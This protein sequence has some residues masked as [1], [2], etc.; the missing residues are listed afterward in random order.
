MK[1]PSCSAESPLDALSCRSCGAPFSQHKSQS[2]LTRTLRLP[3]EDLSKGSVF[4]GRFE[5]LEKLGRGGMGTVYRVLDRTIGEEVALK[6]LKPEVA[7]EEK[8][9]GRFKNELKLARKIIH[10]NVC[11]MFDINQA[12]GTFFITMEYVPGE[13]LKNL[14]RRAGRISPQKAV[15]VARQIS[16]GLAEAHN[17]GVVHR[18]LKPQNIMIDKEGNAH[19]MDFGIARLMGGPEMT[20]A[21]LII[22]TPEA[23]SPEQAEGLPADQR[24]DLYSLGVILY[25]LVT[26]KVPFQ[27]KTALSVAMKHKTEAPVDPRNLNG[28]IPASL[29]LLILRCLAKDPGSRYQDVSELLAGLWEIEDE[30]SGK[31]TASASGKPKSEGHEEEGAIRS[32]A[33]LPFKDMSPQRDQGYFCE[34]LAEELINALT[35]VQDLK[36]AARTSSFSFKEKDA[37]IREIGKSLNVGA[38][39]E[40]S[41]QKAGNRLR[42]T[43]QLI[44]VSDGYHIWSERF[45]KTMD[46]VFAIQDEIA[47][48]IVE[49]LAVKL[50]KGEKEKITK[51][52]TQ[53]KKAYNLYL[54]GRYFWN[55]RYKGDM[56]KAV[57]FY[58]KAVSKD[59]HYA[60]PYVGVADVFNIFGMWAY[61]H[62]KDAYTRSK[63]MLQKALEIDPELSEAYSSLGF[64]TAGYEWN[65][66]A[67]DRY[68]EKSIELSPHNVYA[69]AWRG[70]LLGVW[71]NE[72]MA[73]K[74]LLLAV[75]NDPLFP[76]FRALLGIIISM[77][78]EV[79]KG[80]E[81]LLK[82]L[83]MDPGQP[84]TYLF[85]GVVHLVPPA[86]P[87]KAI[88]Y[89]EK[90]V[91]FGLTFALG[92]LG[93]A[94]ALAGRERDTEEILSR[95]ERIE[96][97]KFMPPLKKF[98]VNL[99]PALRLFRF[100]KYKYVSPLLK[101]LA[102]FSL[103]RIE[104]GLKELEKSAEARD[105]FLPAI[106]LLRSMPNLPIEEKIISHPRFKAL[107]ARLS[108][109]QRGQS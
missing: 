61:I 17:L 59:P 15:S 11:R 19:I 91:G 98:V 76:L 56:I 23:M 45:D 14:I 44:S 54:K 16:E 67:A 24:S 86:E 73:K 42:I 12:E 53:D 72:E 64:M 2:S 13:D 100:L 96:R 77:G 51:R 39:L 92:H 66:E 109:D 37:D 1:C 74:E 8:T 41:V 6:V 46:D 28:E 75:E 102:Y 78:G 7:A 62:P 9:I 21:G 68:Y 88:L 26:G 34:G 101:A 27:G 104:D 22:G 80:R 55:R 90:A 36:V 50:K 43:A 106:L 108:S 3:A 89:L 32:V 49:K 103:K 63:A 83:A 30:M 29:S 85:S 4:A 52:H 71:G 95:L 60:L 93:V 99:I 31:T 82:A 81:H 25:E 48:A 20:E 69:H 84:M 105:Y 10:K 107:Q 35:Q 18:D 79:E 5:V 47:M 87:D 40:G 94:Y 65:F 58:Q 70:E 97:E 57:R 33:V 38:V